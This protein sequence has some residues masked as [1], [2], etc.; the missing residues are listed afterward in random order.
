MAKRPAGLADSPAEPDN[1]VTKGDPAVLP[2]EFHQILLNLLGGGCR[3]QSE[4]ACYAKD[5][6]IHHDA[7]WNPKAGAQDYV[8]GFARNTRQTEHL[9]YRARHFSAE[10]V[11]NSLGCTYNTL[12]LVAKESGGADILLQNFGLER[13]EIL[14]GRIFRKERGRDLV[15]SLVR[16]L[17]RKNRGDKELERVAVVQRA[18]SPREELVQSGKD[19]VQAPG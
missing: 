16:A 10:V 2:D 11:Y 15:H 19:S 9:L 1:L 17:S 3:R 5:V 12:R 4:P 18:F 8:G 14:R 13:R 7:G 6:R